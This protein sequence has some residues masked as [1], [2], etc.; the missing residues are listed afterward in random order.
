MSGANYQEIGARIRMYRKLQGITLENM[1][2]QLHKSKATISKYENGHLVMTIDILLDIAAILKISP[3]HLIALPQKPTMF[4]I[5]TASGFFDCSR[6]YVYFISDC[7]DRI[8]HGVL[9]IQTPNGNCS[10]A[11]YYSAVESF[12]NYTNCQHILHGQIEF[13]HDFTYYI[14]DNCINP[15]EKLFLAVTTPYD[16]K[17]YARGLICAHSIPFRVPMAFKCI[18]SQKILEE[19]DKIREELLINKEDIQVIRKYNALI[20]KD[21]W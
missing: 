17:A 20:R 10:T 8:F 12:E 11:T 15:L 14:A 16:T 6:A 2:R 19:N 4:S 9:D 21:P 1:A 5:P 18:V 13:H 7:S 3:E